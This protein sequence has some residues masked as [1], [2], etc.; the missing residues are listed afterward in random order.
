[1]KRIVS[2]IILLFA[3]LSFGSPAGAV[4]YRYEMLGHVL[5]PW[6]D[7]GCFATSRVDLDGFAYLEDSDPV[8][9]GPTSGYDPFSIVY[10]TVHMH[11]SG[12]DTTNDQ[13]P[14]VWQGDYYYSGSGS[15]NFY[16][17]DVDIM[18]GGGLFTGNFGGPEPGEN[19][20]APSMFA[21]YL[22]SFGVGELPLDWIG[23]ID[24]AMIDTDFYEGS[25]YFRS[26]PVP[27][28]VSALLLGL[29]LLGA[30]GLGK[31]RWR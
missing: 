16:P 26:S 17:N 3:V 12:W 31:R 15:V 6:G 1:M 29:G 18:I 28:P 23:S 30:A 14:P 2:A 11:V 21:A 13:D 20:P 9:T 7:D 8:M 19:L 10:Y 4:L 24:C 25:I 27:E 22:Q 5:F